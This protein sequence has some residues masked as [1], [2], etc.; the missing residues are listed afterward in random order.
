MVALAGQGMSHVQAGILIVEVG[1]IAVGY[2][3]GL[4]RGFGGRPPG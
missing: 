2:L 1:V 3:V 4:V